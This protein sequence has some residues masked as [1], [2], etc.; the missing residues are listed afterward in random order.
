MASLRFA[1]NLDD[2]SAGSTCGVFTLA[3][4]F[5]TTNTDTI[6]HLQRVLAMQ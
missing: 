2:Q 6:E 5:L 1:E 4:D 3:I